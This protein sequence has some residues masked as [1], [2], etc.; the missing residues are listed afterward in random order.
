[1][2][3]KNYSEAAEL[4]RRKILE[5]GIEQPVFTLISSQARDFC[6]LV[7]SQLTDFA[8]LDLATTKTLVILDDGSTPA[9]E[10][11][12]YTDRV[13]QASPTTKIVIATPIVLE[14]DIPIFGSF[15]DSFLYLTSAPAI[16]SVNQFY[17][18]TPLV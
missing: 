3:F 16:F 7:D 17:Q 1:M 13:R 8:Q 14:S 2:I 15:C 18:D 9:F 6:L 5:E 4:L 10:Y 12:E 11:N